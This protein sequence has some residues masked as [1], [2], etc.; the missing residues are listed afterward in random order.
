ME[1][2]E[3]PHV[4]EHTCIHCQGVIK[5]G[6][7]FCNHCGLRQFIPDIDDAVQKQRILIGLSVFFGIQLLVCLISH[8]NTTGHSL[9]SLFVF[10]G[11][12]TIATITYAVIYSRELKPLFRWPHFSI[13]KLFSYVST[14]IIAAI[15][16]NYIVK[17]LNRSIFNA[18]SYYYYAFSNL[19][20]A[21][22]IT[23][24]VVAL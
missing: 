18:E 10:D 11:I 13:V 9:V 5:E 4:N 15:V 21:K 8:F 7:L 2:N 12:I 24:L 20:Y 16:V 22:L 3:M 1:L 6:V 19:K 14:A 17:W 23:V